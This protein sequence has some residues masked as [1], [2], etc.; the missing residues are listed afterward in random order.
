MTYTPGM[1]RSVILLANRSKPDVLT[2]LDEVR[3]LIQSHGRIAAELDASHDAITQLDG[4]LIGHDA[5]LIVVLG[6][7]GTL[8]SQSRRC[9]SLGLPMLGVNLGRLGF[10]AEFDVESLVEQAASLFG[11][12]ELALQDRPLLHVTV[13]GGTSTDAPSPVKFQGLALN[14]AVI[15]AGPPFRMISIS[16][17]IDG[18]EGPSVS[19]DGLIVSTPTGSTAYNVSAGGSIVA[20]EVD[21]MAITPIAAHS[22]AFRPIIVSG[23]STIELVMTR[24]NSR[25]E[26]SKGSPGDDFGTT[27]V[28]D[29]QASTRLQINDRVRLKK[30]PQP[31]RFVRNTRG[32]Y[33]KT[34]VQKLHWAAPPRLR[35]DGE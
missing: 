32:S 13:S 33:W 3:R 7:D 18:E 20:P 27:L 11:G 30:H 9:V 34:L 21:A 31:I 29:G 2:A 1:G 19:G 25:P 26:A 15:T 12:S 4:T 14:D 23:Q 10:M 28:L 24:V 6:G 16:L 8:L 17:S 5:D 22:L 35:S